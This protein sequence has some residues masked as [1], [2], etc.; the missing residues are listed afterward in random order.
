MAGAL[1]GTLLATTGLAK[2][3]IGATRGG[4]GIRWSARWLIRPRGQ[5]TG[6]RGRG[7]WFIRRATAGRAA[8]R[9]AHVRITR[10]RL[11]HG[12]GPSL[13]GTLAGRLPSDGSARPAVR[14]NSLLEL[15]R[16]CMH[17][18]SDDRP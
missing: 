1:R 6:N 18:G 10:V 17:V 4:R 11:R 12:G 15:E 13:T 5:G 2:D 7:V 16:T 8:A 9:R 3:S 14:T